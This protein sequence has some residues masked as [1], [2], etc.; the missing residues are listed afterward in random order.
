MDGTTIFALLATSAI[1]TDIAHRLSF[2]LQTQALHASLREV[3]TLVKIVNKLGMKLDT[4]TADQMIV[5]LE[6]PLFDKLATALNDELKTIA[7]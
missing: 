5:K 4:T 2:W 7:K 1:A 3:P 6:S